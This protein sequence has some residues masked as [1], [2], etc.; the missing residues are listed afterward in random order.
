MNFFA[1][2][3]GVDENSPFGIGLGL[4]S[5][6]LVG[7]GVYRAAKYLT[8]QATTKTASP[9]SGPS[10]QI[11]GKSQ[12]Y[13][14][15]VTNQGFVRADG[16]KMVGS[17]G[18]NYVPA[19]TGTNIAIDPSLNKGVSTGQDVYATAFDS[20]Q[21]S[22][23]DGSLKTTTLPG[24]TWVKKYE[25][26]DGTVLLKGADGSIGTQDANGN[27]VITDSAGNYSQTIAAKTAQ[28]AQAVEVSQ[29]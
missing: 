15:Y 26:S 5:M 1:K 10:G 2:L 18:G 29:L 13:D 4:L 21:K 17:G 12:G 6:G 11:V 19:Q 3:F 25:T 16:V 14:V 9:A 28:P 23:A 8:S 7:Y 20:F 24:P 27:W 22:K